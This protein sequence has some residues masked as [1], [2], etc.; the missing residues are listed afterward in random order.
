MCRS[1]CNQAICRSGCNQAICRSG[2]SRF[3][4]RGKNPAICRSG[5]SRFADRVS[6]ISHSEHHLGPT[7]VSRLPDRAF[8]LGLSS[9]PIGPL[10][11][12]TLNLPWARFMPIG[13]PS[14]AFP[15]PIGNFLMP[16]RAPPISHP[17]TCLGQ[18]Y[19]DRPHK[20]SIRPIDS[21]KAPQKAIELDRKPVLHQ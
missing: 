10:R 5:C 4:D 17:K 3:A 14:W 16:D 11:Q 19:A 7:W 6:P 15:Q 2:H 8:S 13:H 12:A 18:T 20:F 9:R 21:E 1:G